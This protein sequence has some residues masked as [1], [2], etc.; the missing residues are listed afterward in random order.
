MSDYF[1]FNCETSITLGMLS[2][3]FRRQGP[4]PIFP[5]TLSIEK[6]NTRARNHEEWS[7]GISYS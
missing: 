3:L 1:N 4:V 2:I 6:Q 7:L 5:H